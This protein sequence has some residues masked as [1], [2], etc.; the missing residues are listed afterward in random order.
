MRAGRGV[1][2]YVRAAR[3]RRSPG[4]RRT[5]ERSG[6]PLGGRAG[7]GSGLG[8]DRRRARAADSRRGD[9]A[10]DPLRRGRVR[11][12]PVPRGVHPD[13]LRR[14][15]ALSGV[16][17]GL[18]AERRAAP[19]RR[20]A[21]ASRLRPDPGADRPRRSGRADRGS[22]RAGRRRGHGAERRP[23]H[24]GRPVPLPLLPARAGSGHLPRLRDR[25]GRTDLER[26]H[27]H[28]P[29]PEHPG[30]LR[31]GRLRLR[32]PP[33]RFTCWPRRSRSPSPTAR[34]TSAT[35]RS[36]TCRSPG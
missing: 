23:D 2:R 8:V 22:D 33:R 35:R 11:R 12:L 34:P 24:P 14:P 6:I 9:G 5:S 28:R 36:S 18:P 16:G 1:A 10:G 7:G 25:L 17:G 30:R 3:G 21:R 29:G 15:G 19:S 13:R 4:G 32:H 27:P 26:R 20:A 31:P